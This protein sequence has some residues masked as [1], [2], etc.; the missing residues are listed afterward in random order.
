[1]PKRGDL[2]VRRI[3]DKKPFYITSESLSVA[4]IN[5]NIYEIIGVVIKRIGKKVLTA[6]KFN[7]SKTW[8]DRYSYRLSGYTLD[9]TNRSGV[10]SIRVSSS[11]S[12]NTDYT[13]SYNATTIEAF[14]LQL[15]SFFANT[16]IFNSQDWYAETDGSNVDVH[17]AHTFWQQSSYNVAKNGFAMSAN[18]LPDVPAL[19]NIRRRNGAKGGEG[20]ISSWY[21]ALVYFRGD[22]SSTT[23]NPNADVTNI[24]R[25]YPICLPGYLGTSKYQSDHCAFLRSVFGGGEE[26]WLKFME[27]CLPVVDSENGN[28]GQDFGEEMT[29]L[30]AGKRYSSRLKTN[31]PF[32]KAADYCYNLEGQTFSKGECHLPTT[33]EIALLLDGIQYGTIGDRNADVV[34]ITL[35]KIGGNAISNGSHLWSCCRSSAYGAWYA[36]G[37]YGFFNGYGFYVSNL[38][39]PLL[40]HIL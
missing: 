3:S 10:F 33:K 4:E 37:G 7:A 36:N 39:C 6:Y 12:A 2:E 38:C 34:N 9:G 26:G 31:E 25:T 17:F 40:L 29:T 30:L 11:A 19:A 24:K 32:C 16:D 5:T 23:Y 8:C 20:V 14:V 13:F 15:N 18:T 22:N 1:M 27:S 28:M 35:N 21:R